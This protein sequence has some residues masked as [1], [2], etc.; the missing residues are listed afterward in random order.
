MI[1][2]HLTTMNNH[3]ITPWRAGLRRAAWLPAL[4]ALL[5]VGGTTVVPAIE[6]VELVNFVMCDGGSNDFLGSDSVYGVAIADDTAYVQL[7]GASLPQIN[8]I[9]NLSGGQATTRLV[10]PAQWLAASGKTSMSS[11]YGLGVWSNIVQFA[12]VSS[13][14]IWRINKITGELS[15]YADITSITNATGST[16]GVNILAPQTI[17]PA[18][19]EQ[20]FYENK[21]KHVLTTGGSNVVSIFM[22]YEELSNTFGNAGVS[23]GMTFDHDGNFY[24]MQYESG[25]YLGVHKRA[26]NGTLSVF[27]TKAQM[28]AVHGAGYT[29]PGDLFFAPDGKLYIRLYISTRGCVLQCD[30]ASTNPAGTLA[31]Y[32]SESALSNSAARSAN[33][34]QMSWYKGGL[35]WHHFKEGTW[36]SG[37]FAVVPTNEP[38][39]VV[40]GPAEV[41][42]NTSNVP[43]GCMLLLTNRW[44]LYTRY[45][46][47]ATS[48]WSIVGGT[49]AGVTL[50]G[51]FLSVASDVPTNQ[52]ITLQAAS[53]YA[54]QPLTNT[55]AVLL[56]PEPAALS[57]GLLLI[58]VG[59][60]RPV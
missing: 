48:Q 42:I 49:P 11:W 40:S 32:L 24:W 29:V 37:I 60:V 6:T 3:T 23:G 18:T 20:V 33:M 56:V 12:D 38:V 47:T 36:R 21:G 30:P 5:L 31:M 4:G 14:E 45:D 50:D 19:G 27:L 46:Q 53:S 34:T 35:C 58:C 16:N 39:L 26:T 22:S 59:R 54:G 9:D 28:D 13:D 15:K 8:R 17:N 25:Y 10:S 57:L 43:Y 52:Y 1:T 7:T 44:G 2:H 51:N 55:Y 41:A